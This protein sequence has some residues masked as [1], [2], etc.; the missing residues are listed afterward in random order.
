M[1]QRKNYLAAR[2][3]NNKFIALNEGNHLFTWDILSG[4]LMMEWDLGFNDTNQDYSN[5]CIYKMNAT[6]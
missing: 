1:K 6:D 5:Y 2:M 4:K 3:L